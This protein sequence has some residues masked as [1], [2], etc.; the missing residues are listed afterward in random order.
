MFVVVFFSIRVGKSVPES[1]NNSNSSNN[2]FSSTAIWT[3]S[4]AHDGIAD[5]DALFTVGVKDII[6]YCF[7]YNCGIVY[8][9]CLQ[10]FDTV[11]CVASSL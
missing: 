7:L 6:C 2:S 8:C 1:H 4:L 5:L 9:I 11:G 10:C 3:C